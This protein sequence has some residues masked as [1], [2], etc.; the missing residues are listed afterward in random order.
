M[1]AQV[2]K[3]KPAHW[4]GAVEQTRRHLATICGGCH[5]GG[6][7]GRGCVC[8]QEWGCGRCPSSHGHTDTATAPEASALHNSHE[9]NSKQKRGEIEPAPRP[10]P[11]IKKNNL[12][13]NLK[14]SL[15][16]MRAQGS[17]QAQSQP[18]NRKQLSGEPRPVSCRGGSGSHHTTATKATEQDRVMTLSKKKK[19]A[20]Q[21]CHNTSQAER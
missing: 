7:G 4:W 2:T 9:Q 6:G 3:Q 21:N 15:I 20:Y 1:T 11:K 5:R 19:E 18:D 16:T 17:R 12:N 10:M 8:G 13:K 14:I